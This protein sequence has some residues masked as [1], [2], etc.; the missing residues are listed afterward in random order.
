MKNAMAL[1][2]EAV[3][4]SK[5]DFTVISID[6]AVVLLAVPVV[7]EMAMESLFGIVD[8][9]FVAHLGAVATATV[10]LT[11]GLMIVVSTIAAGLSAGAAAMVSRRVG[12]KDGDG[13][14]DAA[15]QSILLG[16]VASALLFVLCLP[17]APS[18]LSWMGAGPEIVRAG[19]AY[20][21][22]TMSSSGIVLMLFL[23]NAILRSSGDAATAMRVLW[24]ANLVNLCLDPC[25]ILGL[26]PFPKLGV[27]G[28]ALAT[29][30][31]RSLGVVAQLFILCR[32]LG[33]VVIGRKHLKVNFKLLTG[34]L[35]IGVSGTL[36]SGITL[37]SWLVMARL[38]Q[39]FGAA[40]AAGYTV[41]LRIVVFS[42]VPSWG[43]SAAAATLVGQNLGA[44]QYQRAEQAVW[45]A[46]FFNMIFLGSLSAIFLFFA[47][48]IG[49][50]FSEDPAVIAASASCLRIMSLCYV[51]YA[52]GLVIV[53]A[54][55]GAGDTLTPSVINIVCYWVVQLPLAFLLGR[56]LQF[57]PNGLFF[58][59]FT[60]QLVMSLVSIGVFRR[61]K[62]K[63]YAV[64]GAEPA[65]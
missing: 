37:S 14:A 36:Q 54:L 43:L 28:A 38:V 4:G 60:S 45:R 8:I 55:N 22:I 51:I 59:I 3:W 1:I 26:G 44:R 24:L 58:A 2:R 20:T 16:I 48:S 12:E 35:K 34:I 50:I 18:L 27:T 49:R 31:G 10:G 19:S 15:V 46:G 63:T 30:I 52:W 25:L 23:M 21:R 17:L 40:V 33:R 29:L 42:M 32:G 11:E 61:G 13:A 53:Q 5:Q 64:L 7:L 56:R 41:A 6:R 47:P 39:S 57:G 9:I 65:A 62:W